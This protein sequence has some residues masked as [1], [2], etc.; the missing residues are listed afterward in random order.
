MK[1]LQEFSKRIEERRE[2]ENARLD[3]EQ[4]QRKIRLNQLEAQKHSGIDRLKII[5]NRKEGKEKETLRREI[6]AY[7]SYKNRKRLTSPQKIAIGAG[8]VAM[9]CLCAFLEKAE[10]VDVASTDQ[11][12]SE[13]VEIS[14][15]KS[16][17][18]DDRITEPTSK[19]DSPVK[20]GENNDDDA[21]DA[22]TK[23]NKSDSIEADSSAAQNVQ[24]LPDKNRGYDFG[25]DI[26]SDT[27][28]ISEYL[29]DF[30]KQ[31]MTSWTVK[32]G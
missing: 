30:D 14:I 21:T 2:A 4:R 19:D 11:A 29:V 32:L 31:I 23:P 6:A 12:K 3:E 7:E 1:V 10:E 27:Y 25:F 9:F 28:S 20:N 24:K 26:R 16:V 5:K 22:K 8:I 15:S 13:Q 18:E 17:A